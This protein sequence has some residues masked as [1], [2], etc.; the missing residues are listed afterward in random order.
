MSEETV[1]SIATLVGG[2]VHGDASRPITGVADFR[3]AGPGHVGF[4]NDKNLVAEADRRQMI[5]GIYSVLK[6][7]GRIAIADI[8]SE[9]R[10]PQTMKQDAELW[11]GC[12]SGA[13]QK[14][15]FL[16]AFENA[17]FKSVRYD[18]FEKEAWQEV[19]GLKFFSATVCAEK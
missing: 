5:E 11:S 7:G 4:L 17:G 3:R 13:F 16:Q 2:A 1:G 18:V 6:P 10:V 8:V 19:Q 12:I 14:E 9:E 15:D